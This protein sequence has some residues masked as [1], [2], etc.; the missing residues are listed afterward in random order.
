M[1]D[2]YIFEFKARQPPSWCFGFPEIH[3]VF[4]MNQKWIIEE[5]SWG[6][7]SVSTIGQRGLPGTQTSNLPESKDCAPPPNQ[8]LGHRAA[9]NQTRAC[10][11]LL[12]TW[13]TKPASSGAPGIRNNTNRMMRRCPAKLSITSYIFLLFL[14][15][16]N[17]SIIVTN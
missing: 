4:F 1:W 2:T 17:I 16:F 8:L 11:L 5:S 10:T 7:A 6:V 9:A 3:L 13:R 12:C 14:L 15:E